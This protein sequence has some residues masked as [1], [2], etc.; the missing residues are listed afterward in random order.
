LLEASHLDNALVEE[1]TDF[2]EGIFEGYEQAKAA[3]AK[4]KGTA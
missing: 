1:Q 3:I 2:V 4:A